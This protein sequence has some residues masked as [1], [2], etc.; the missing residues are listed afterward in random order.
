LEQTPIFERNFNSAL[1][2]SG[3]PAEWTTV[4]RLGRE[5][6]V[7]L[8]TIQVSADEITTRMGMSRRTFHRRLKDC[9]VKFQDILH[10]MRCE[11]AEPLLMNTG[12]SISK[13]ATIGLRRAKHL[14]AAVCSLDRNV[15]K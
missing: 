9:G 15:S 12:L 8:I 6:T 10:E 7:A 2:Q 14:D 4:T 3:M 13:I 1:K 5:L 11:F